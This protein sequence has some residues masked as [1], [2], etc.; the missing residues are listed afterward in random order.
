MTCGILKSLFKASIQKAW[1]RLSTQLI[2]ATS[3]AKRSNATF[4]AEELSNVSSYQT[5]KTDRNW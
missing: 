3:C 5:Q 4:G 1:N 2:E